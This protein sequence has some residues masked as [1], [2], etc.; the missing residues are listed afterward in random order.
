MRLYKRTRILSCHIHLILG[1]DPDINGRK[2]IANLNMDFVRRDIT[3]KCLAIGEKGS[4]RWCGITGNVE[5][6]PAD[7]THWK[8]IFSSSTKMDE[9]YILE[10]QHFLGCIDKSSRPLIDGQDGL[11]VLKIIEAAQKS[12]SMNN[13]V[14]VEKQNQ[15]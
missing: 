4:L 6:F 9:S 2:L 14:H 1:F 7:G 15:I 10:W 5:I 11:S 8:S 12:A 13:V 3:R